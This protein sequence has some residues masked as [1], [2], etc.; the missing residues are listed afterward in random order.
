M[1]NDPARSLV[2][3]A[4]EAKVEKEAKL[5]LENPR[6]VLNHAQLELDYR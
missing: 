2:K 6:R 4:K 5:D 3:E 1:L